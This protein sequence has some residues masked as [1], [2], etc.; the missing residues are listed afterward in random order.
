MNNNENINQS[1]IRIGNKQL[2]K[3]NNAIQI[4]NKL[5]S[6]NI[7]KLFNQAFY[8]LNSGDLFEVEG[9][10][11]FYNYS[12]I[13][14][15]EVVGKEID[16]N[17]LYH[18]ET[19]SQYFRKMRFRYNTNYEDC[20]KAYELFSEVIETNPSQKYSYFFRG[21]AK[22]EL[23]KFDTNNKNFDN[24]NED[25]LNAIKIDP[26]F[27]Y[28]YIKLGIYDWKEELQNLNKIIEINPHFEDA[29]IRRSYVKEILKDYE[30]AILD[31][32]IA[33]EICNKNPFA[34]KQRGE[35]KFKIKDYLG[36]I[37]DFSNA[38]E[39]CP[40]D[41]P[42]IWDLRSIAKERLGDVEGSKADIRKVK[43]IDPTY[44]ATQEF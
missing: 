22:Q 7:D 30:G 2:V 6:K 32:T 15:G 39:I 18:F 43:W 10:I 21:I 44:Y 25:F 3:T 36:A 29:F 9:K 11:L 38:I 1:L 40:N 26:T 5:I 24:A 13:Y 16:T 41:M 31:A 19:D 8:L 35:V 20:M 37:D 12:V 42:I 14:Y 17:F 33:I 23:H 27:V 34:F 28:A 4:T